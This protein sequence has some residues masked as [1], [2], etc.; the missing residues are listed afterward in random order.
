[1]LTIAEPCTLPLCFP[2]DY[3]FLCR[4][5]SFDAT[6]HSRIAAF[7]AAHTGRGSHSGGGRKGGKRRG[8][9]I[10]WLVHRLAN[11]L[12]FERRCRGPVPG[13]VSS[14]DKGDP[15]AKAG[16]RRSERGGVRSVR[17]TSERRARPTQPGDRLSQQKRQPCG[18]PAPA[19]RGRT[20]S[21]LSDS[22]RPARRTAS[23]T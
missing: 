7:S 13:R 12:A 14:R 10:L 16:K 1:M 11:T 8:E 23:T 9:R 3:P 19:A 4:N 22:L 20:A 2:L 18:R 21:P 5:L 6:P 15:L 17:R